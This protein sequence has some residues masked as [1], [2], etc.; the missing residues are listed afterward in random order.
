MRLRRLFL[1]AQI[2]FWLYYDF[3]VPI[4]AIVESVAY[5]CPIPGC[6]HVFREKNCNW[7]NVSVHLRRGTLR[8]GD[9]HNKVWIA[10]QA[11][12]KKYGGK[13]SIAKAFYAAMALRGKGM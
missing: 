9:T 5:T 8:T 4:K 2:T 3:F 11:E 10:Q 6:G 1:C 7:T 13:C 12:K